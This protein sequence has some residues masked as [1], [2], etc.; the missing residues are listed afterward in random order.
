LSSSLS[1]PDSARNKTRS[2]SSPGRTPFESRLVRF[3]L[4][5]CMARFRSVP[6]IF[7]RDELFTCP[8]PMR[9]LPAVLLFVSLDLRTDQGRLNLSSATGRV[10]PSPEVEG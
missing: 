8:S 9:F 7:D 10:S 2:E 5:M 1:E 4:S 3:S 6:T